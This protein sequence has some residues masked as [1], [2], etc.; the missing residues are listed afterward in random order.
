MQAELLKQQTGTSFIHVPYKGDTPALQ[1]T[2]SGQVQFMF[3]PVAAALPHVRSGRLRALA[4][5]SA[6]RLAMLPDVPT[7]TEEG[8]NDFV[9]EQWQA[10]FAPAGT[11]AAVVQRLNQEMNKVLADPDVTGLA[12]KLGV[13]LVG[14]TPRQL[15]DRQKADSAKWA[16]V[17]RDGGIKLE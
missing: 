5:T 16:K 8:L 4:T 7:M 1:D 10:V 6:K 11:P 17:I 9:V 3:A 2:L 13:T 14:G 12:D 15:G